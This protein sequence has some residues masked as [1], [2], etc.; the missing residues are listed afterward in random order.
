MRERYG[1]RELTPTTLAH[2][3]TLNRCDQRQKSS[4][5]V[6]HLLEL[7]E[8]NELVPLGYGQS[9]LKHPISFK[10]DDIYVP[11]SV[12]HITYLLKPQSNCEIECFIESTEFQSPLFEQSAVLIV[13]IKLHEDSE[14]YHPKGGKGGG[15]PFA[16]TI[17]EEGKT[18]VVLQATSQPDGVKELEKKG[19]TVTRFDIMNR[20]NGKI[21]SDLT[22]DGK[23]CKFAY[24]K[25][26]LPK[27][28]ELEQDMY[29]VLP[30]NNE[31]LLEAL[32]EGFGVS[33][34]A[35]IAFMDLKAFRAD[36][37]R[38]FK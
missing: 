37:L 22:R 4:V 31:K 38:F 35:R 32:R 28:K 30:L 36:P 20:L 26:T 9:E 3:Y 27:K 5:A 15:K 11:A 29:V 34:A 2:E 7:P 33:G 21:K 1:F 12:V 10:V 13:R 23:T 6:L 19:I 17:K 16:I 24:T 25:V 8:L 18:D 14:P